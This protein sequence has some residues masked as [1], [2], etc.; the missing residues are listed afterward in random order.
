MFVG[1]RLVELVCKLEKKEISQT[2]VTSQGE[3]YHQQLKRACFCIRRLPLWPN[4][5]GSWPGAA[6]S[7]CVVIY[8][9]TFINLV[10][11]VFLSLSLLPLKR[12]LLNETKRVRVVG[13][14]KWLSCICLQCEVWKWRRMVN[15]RS[16]SLPVFLCAHR[17]NKQANN[18][19]RTTKFKIN[20]TYI[21][22]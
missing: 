3:Q 17:N 10:S 20:N 18:N 11:L 5:D 15:Q 7:C 21:T 2:C 14:E 8:F 12:F 9:E 4:D 16:N 6:C 1:L 19:V 22:A 13:E